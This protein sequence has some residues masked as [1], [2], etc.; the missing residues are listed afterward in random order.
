M[1]GNVSVTSTPVCGFSWDYHCDII[2]TS[3]QVLFS[4]LFIAAGEAP[5]PKMH[6]CLLVVNEV[7]YLG[8]FIAFDNV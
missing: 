3:V 5:A 7:A 6:G 1:S 4:I 2:I 8:I